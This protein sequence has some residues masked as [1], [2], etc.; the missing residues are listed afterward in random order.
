MPKIPPPPPRISLS[1]NLH[2][3]ELPPPPPPTHT[4]PVQYTYVIKAVENKS[5]NASYSRTFQ[6]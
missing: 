2:H 1:H 5:N 4:V 6:A 3:A